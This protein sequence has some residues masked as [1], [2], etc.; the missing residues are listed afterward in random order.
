MYV[1]SLNHRETSSVFSAGQEVKFTSSI[2]SISDAFK[3]E[4][5]VRLLMDDDFCRYE[6]R[7]SRRLYLEDPILPLVK[8]KLEDEGVCNNHR[9]RLAVGRVGKVSEVGR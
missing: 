5:D 8:G 4:M 9:H 7:L 2:T 3:T 1:V 6:N